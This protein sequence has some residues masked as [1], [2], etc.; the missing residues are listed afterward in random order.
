MRRISLP[1]HGLPVATRIERRDRIAKLGVRKLT[2]L[3]GVARDVSRVAT[4]LFLHLDELGLVRDV[5]VLV[6]PHSSIAEQSFGA[7]RGFGVTV[8]CSKRR[9]AYIVVAGRS[10]RG[11]PRSEFLR[12]H[13]P[14]TFAHEWAH[15]DQWQNRGKWQE[16]GIE[17]RA[18]TLLRGF[19]PRGRR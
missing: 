18:R 5:S 3:R 15:V 7:E 8:R 9:G 14:Q 6:V 4:A 10:L 13:F 17:V 16:R 12:A 19:D 11:E 2:V 1:L